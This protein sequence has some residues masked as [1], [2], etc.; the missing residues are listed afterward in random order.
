MGR[1]Y[2]RLVA[3]YLPFAFLALS[4][5]A[6]GQWVDQTFNLQQG[7]NAI[8]LEV[9]PATDDV[10]TEFSTNPGGIIQRFWYWQVD[11][12]SNGLTCTDPSDPQCEPDTDTQWRLWQAS[13]PSTNVNNLRVLTGGRVYLV[14]TTAA[15]TVTVRGRPNSLRQMW[16][17]GLNVVGFHVDPASP[18]TFAEYLGPSGHHSPFEIY[19]MSSSGSITRIADPTSAAIVPG[20]GYWVRA[21]GSFIYD[22]PISIDARSL[23]GVQYERRIVEHVLQFENLATAA[24]SV[25]LK[26]L[27]SQQRPTQATDLPERGAATPPPVRYRS[28]V[29]NDQES[30]Q[31]VDL[32]LN[33][34]V[35]FNVA[36]ANTSE[37]QRAR[38]ILQLSVVRRGQSRAEIAFNN[39]QHMA[40]LQVTDG[41]GFRRLLPVTCE[42]TSAA[43]LYFG[44][45]TVDQV[46]WVQSDARIAPPVPPETTP[47]AGDQY[48]NT[49]TEPNPDTDP[50]G[51]FE[52]RPT[53]YA[54]SFPIILH[55]DGGSTYTFLNDVTLLYN[56]TIQQ[57]VLKTPSCTDC[58]ELVAGSVLDGQPFARH[59]STA[60]FS[61][62]NDLAMTGS[63]DSTL[64]VDVVVAEN[65]KLNPFLHKYH[66]HHDGD[67]FNE[68]WG[69]SRHLELDFGC[70]P[71]NTNE[72][73]GDGDLV[74]VGCYRETL[75]GTTDAEGNEI[76]GLHVRPINVAGK[77]ELRR[78]S[79]LATLNQ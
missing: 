27:A 16:Q 20:R 47:G 45:V 15:G 46:A 64:S 57:F 77:I 17:D 29:P 19:Q 13:T 34:A 73:P 4:T 36:A 11:T 79:T 70:S 38:K 3:V 39:Q 65:D 66:P 6:L 43:G 78:V 10:P 58:S 53:P 14:E 56:P 31:L 42:V 61:F 41:A 24:R 52:P 1:A 62:V 40:I 50:R 72:R 21:D 51:I 60:A 54:F 26:L 75:A 8:F 67:R 55:Y 76:P 7:W 33:T 74:L 18:P 22:G 32:P 49:Q 35:P 71:P 63:F 68:V 28:Y 37:P 12:N 69:V 23:V 2:P 5:S 25:S 30:Y 9:D 44:V 59:I 48:E